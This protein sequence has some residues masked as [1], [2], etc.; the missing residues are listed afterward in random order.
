MTKDSN[1]WFP[2]PS[3]KW[4]R[5][6]DQVA[7]LRLEWPQEELAAIWRH[8]LAAPVQAEAPGVR[9][10]LDEGLGRRVAGLVRGRCIVTFGDLFQHPHPPMELLQE[11]KDFAKANRDHPESLLPPEIS[12]LLYYAS[13]AAALLRCGHRISRLDDVAL[14]QG[15]EWA[16]AQPGLDEKTLTLLK[17]GLEFLPRH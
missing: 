15:I 1:A 10:P 7:K 4:S 3:E 12:S 14:R 13:I 8:Q 16:L 5:V 9:I 2:S 11:V 17:A 6:M